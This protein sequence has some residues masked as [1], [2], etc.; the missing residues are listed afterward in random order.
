MKKSHP[1]WRPN[2]PLILCYGVAALSVISAL[3]IAQ[4]LTINSNT[5]IVALSALF[6]G[7]LSPAPRSVAESI[8]RAR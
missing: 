6:V 8:R 2:P 3:L 5:L 4:W 7:L 1:H